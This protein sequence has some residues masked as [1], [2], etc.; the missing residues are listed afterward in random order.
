MGFLLAFPRLPI[1]EVLDLRDEIK[2]PVVRFRGEISTLAKAFETRSIDETFDA[3]V[4]DAW[5]QTVAPSLSTIASAAVWRL[6]RRR[7]CSSRRSCS[8]SGSAS[9]SFSRSANRFDSMM[10][11]SPASLTSIVFTTMLTARGSSSS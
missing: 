3:E 6:L 5:R 7:Y 9:W 2:T 11:S 1:D 4:E 10:S 8:S